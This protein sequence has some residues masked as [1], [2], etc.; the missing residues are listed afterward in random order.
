MSKYILTGKVKNSHISVNPTFF[1]ENYIMTLPFTNKNLISEVLNGQK[2]DY[3]ITDKLGYGGFGETYL[4]EEVNNPDQKWVIKRLKPNQNKQRLGRYELMKIKELFQK[5]AKNLDKLNHRQIP[6]LKEFFHDHQKLAFIIKQEFYLVQEYIEGHDLRDELIP[7]K[8]LDYQQVWQILYDI[9]E[10]LAFVHSKGLIHRDIKPE[11]IR[12]REKDGKLFL[13]DF[14]SVKDMTEDKRRKSSIFSYTEAYTPMEQKSGF[15]TFTIDVYAVGMIGI[16]ALTGIHPD[17]RSQRYITIDDDTDKFIWREYAGEINEEL[18]KLADIIDVMVHPHWEKR[19][20]NATKA[21]EALEKIRPP[22]NVIRIPNYANIPDIIT[23]PV[24]SPQEI[25]AIIAKPVNSPQEIVA[26]IINTVLTLPEFYTIDITAD[27]KIINNNQDIVNQNIFLKPILVVAGVLTSVACVGIGFSLISSLKTTQK[28]PEIQKIQKTQI[29]EIQPDI[30]KE[31]LT[32][33]YN[34]QEADKK[35]TIKYSDQWIAEEIKEQSEKVKFKRKDKS[36]TDNCPVE[37][38]VSVD[39][40]GE[41]LL[42]EEHKQNVLK[43][44]QNDGLSH[45]ERENEKVRL[46]NTDNAYQIRWNRKENGCTF[47]ILERGTLALKNAY[48]ITYQAPVGE[49]DKFWPVVE[50]MI[51]S[52]HIEE[53]K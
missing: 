2:G 5:E 4:A 7:S 47:K 6:K 15:P 42:L 10:V 44:N 23:E 50:K 9:L 29:P 49:N 34:H 19:Y 17:V 28:K 41:A 30:S 22:H 13:L 1:T 20:N 26:N 52:F 45:L 16:E 12:R 39:D 11:N 25:V 35:F 36:Q 31:E 8:R 18:K 40:L 3:K 37:I 43:K 27:T 14:G 46:D 24:N 32:K 48:Y 33:T 38:L 51:D 53:G 21:L